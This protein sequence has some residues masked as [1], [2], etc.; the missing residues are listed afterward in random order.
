MGLVTC[1]WNSGGLTGNVQT[2]AER[3]VFAWPWEEKTWGTS[4]F[5]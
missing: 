3:D 5:A 4:H 2:A 1:R